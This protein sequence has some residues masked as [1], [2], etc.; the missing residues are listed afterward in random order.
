MKTLIVIGYVWPEPDSSAAGMRMMQLLTLYR[1]ASYRVIF[2]S[3][4]DFSSHAINLDDHGIE[5]VTIQLNCSSFDEWV[6]KQAPDVVMFD[7]FMMEEQFGWRVEEQ[8]PSALRILDMEDVHCLRDARHKAIKAGRELHPDDWH[9]DIAYREI[10]A[11]LRCDLSLVIS[12]YEM[13]WLTEIGRASCRE[14][15]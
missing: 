11:I 9:S 12:E 13:Q 7:R 15:V 2:A 1:E 6:A 14:R 5:S 4:A 8:C 3:P 10:A